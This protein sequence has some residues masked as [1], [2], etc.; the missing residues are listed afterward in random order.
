MIDLYKGPMQYEMYD[1][2]IKDFETVQILDPWSLYDHSWA[3]DKD[4]VI[5]RVECKDGVFLVMIKKKL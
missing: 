3:T 4:E 2:S 1:V 5:L